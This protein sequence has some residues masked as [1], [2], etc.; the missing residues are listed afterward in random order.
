MDSHVRLEY[1]CILLFVELHFEQAEMDI[2]SIRLTRVI[3]AVHA[4]S[5]GL[6]WARAQ[7]T[8]R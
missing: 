4:V 8:A 1:I 5:S 2:P 6:S 3:P 7:E